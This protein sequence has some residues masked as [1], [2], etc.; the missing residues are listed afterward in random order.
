MKKKELLQRIEDLESRFNTQEK[1]T[2]QMSKIIALCVTDRQKYNQC[3][4]K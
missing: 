2:V 4:N 1:L 3:N